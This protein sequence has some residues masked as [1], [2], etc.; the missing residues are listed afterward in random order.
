[1][2]DRALAAI[3]KVSLGSIDSLP[4][5]RSDDRVGTPSHAPA[6][7]FDTERP[8]RD[9]PA[10][11]ATRTLHWLWHRI[12]YGAFR[13][14]STM[15]LVAGVLI[16]VFAQVFAYY[17]RGALAGAPLLASAIY[18]PALGAMA[19]LR[20]HMLSDGTSRSGLTPRRSGTVLVA[21][22]LIA[23]SALCAT[24]QPVLARWTHGLSESSMW[25][26]LAGSL[27]F[28]YCLLMSEVLF[29]SA[30]N[31]KKAAYTATLREDDD[32][33]GRYGAI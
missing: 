33:D 13:A 6:H 24:V 1:M 8:L 10:N 14:L 5:F 31:L 12:G 11:G 15:N 29:A 19:V 25:L 28:F 2:G 18:V 9:E 30:I 23:G 26:G 27:A 20:E 4:G 7:V 3:E 21:Y 16:G 32:R 17:Y 22:T